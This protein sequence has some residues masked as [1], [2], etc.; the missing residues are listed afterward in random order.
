MLKIKLYYVSHTEFD[1]PFTEAFAFYASLTENYKR[2]DIITSEITYHKT[3][4]GAVPAF[5]FAF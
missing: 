1:S 4:L 3:N 5:L 2:R